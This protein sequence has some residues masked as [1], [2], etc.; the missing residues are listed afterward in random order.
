[1]C[2][3]F[4]FLSIFKARIVYENN[5][6]CMCIISLFLSIF[7]ARIV[8]ESNESKVKED[9]S[10]VDRPMIEQLSVHG[11]SDPRGGLHCL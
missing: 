7:K 4:F 2:T 5:E 8:Y 10:R 1:M 9:D 3:I 11:R 6:F